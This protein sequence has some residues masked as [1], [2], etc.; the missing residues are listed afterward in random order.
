MTTDTEIVDAIVVGG[1]PAGLAAALSLCR[2]NHTV[3]LFDSSKFRNKPGLKMHMVATWDHRSPIDF[4]NAAR[5]E[6]A[7]RYGD[8]CTLVDHEVVTVT[9]R[10]EAGPDAAFEARDAAGKKFRGRKIV[11]ATGSRQLF[12]AIDGFD[13]CWGQGV[14]HCL[15][16]KGY[17]HRGAKEAGI[18]AIEE[19]AEP[20]TVLRVLRSCKQLASR[21]RLYT[22][23]NTRVAAQL[24]D[25][26]AMVPGTTVEA[27][28]IE[29]L[30]K[31]E[32]QGERN[33][34]VV[35]EDGVGAHELAFVV[36]HPGTEQASVLPEQLGVG[37]DAN[38]DVELGAFQETSQRGIFAAGD[39]ASKLKYVSTAS[40]M[41]FMTGAGVGMQL[42]AEHKFE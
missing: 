8:L 39:C 30:E 35:L 11:L 5:A 40:A 23:G 22:H 41:G 25:I 20:S 18:L 10:H 29:R 19:F 26:A 4:R 7:L 24:R 37:L 3:A 9:R 6:L 1:G 16:C 38:G 31:L 32:G 15:L 33:L 13:D 36:Y 42:E 21:V 2:Q 12:P 28:V 17:E 27:A 14:L 34:R